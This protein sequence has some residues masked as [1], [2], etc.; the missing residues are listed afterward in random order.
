[1][2]TQNKTYSRPCCDGEQPGQGILSVTG[3]TRRVLAYNDKLF[4]AEHSW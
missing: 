3:L 1:M 2:E 4:L